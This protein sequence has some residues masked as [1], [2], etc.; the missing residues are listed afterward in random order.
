[1][2]SFVQEMKADPKLASEFKAAYTEMV[3]AIEEGRMKFRDKGAIQMR[4][5]DAREREVKSFAATQLEARQKYRGVEKETYE[6]QY[7][8][9]I[10]EKNMIVQ[11]VRAGGVY[12]EIV[13]VPTLPEG[14]WDVDAVDIEGVEHS[15]V[16]DDGKA[17]LRDRQLQ[18][19]FAAIAQSRLAAAVSSQANAKIEEDAAIEEAEDVRAGSDEASEADTE[20]ASGDDEEDDLKYIRASI[21]DEGDT[22][23]RNKQGAASNSQAARSVHSVGSSVQ[24]LQL[25]GRPGP[26]AEGVP[27]ASQGRGADKFAG[28]SVE[29]ILKKHGWEKAVKKLKEASA[30]LQKDGFNT[31]SSLSVPASAFKQAFAEFKPAANQLHKDVVSLDIKVK[32]WNV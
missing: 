23:G 30:E 8:G 26:P 4:L 20:D 15:Q 2:D 21:F 14:H 28:K 6:K 27:E 10:K 9:R 1:M 29:E 18:D 16:E 22:A 12:K 7:P 3:S 31:L 5:M 25:R 19:K 17:V 11:K 32:K 24:T 13:L